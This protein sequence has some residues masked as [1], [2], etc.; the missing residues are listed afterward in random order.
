MKR[1]I[2]TW[3]SGVDERDSAFDDCPDLP[4]LPLRLSEELDRE[5]SSEEEL[6]LPR[7]DR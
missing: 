3:E 2:F 6:C 4:T 1:T 5:D 7:R